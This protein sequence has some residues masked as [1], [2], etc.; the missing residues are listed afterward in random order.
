MKPITQAWLDRA[1]DDLN[2]IEQMVELEHLTNIVA[3]HAQQA[4]EKTLKAIIE[5]TEIGL[6]KTHNLTRLYALVKPHY[7]L[8]EDI[9]TLEQL[10][11][12]YTES[13][14]PDDIGLLPYGKPTIEESLYFYN[15]AK[16][17]YEQAKV[18]LET[19]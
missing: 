6:V 15:F 10:D 16:R 19:Q 14:Y 7:N 8:I 5:E 11:A 18:K 2:A 4:I 17:F 3:F 12:V 9:D 13:R 1:L